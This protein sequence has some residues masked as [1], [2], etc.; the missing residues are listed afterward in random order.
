MSDTGENLLRWW[1]K[2]LRPE[3]GDTAAAR[4]LRAKLRRAD[5]A[6]EV[7]SEPAVYQ[8]AN[9]L[10]F[11]RNRPQDL[12]RLAQV[13]A[14]VKSHNKKR[15]AQVLGTGTPPPFSTQRFQRLIRTNEDGL[16]T[17]LR[18]A[19]PQAGETCDVAALGQDLLNWNEQTRIRWC[20]DYFGAAHPGA[21]GKDDAAGKDI[22]KDTTS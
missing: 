8:L 20:F 1:R 5:S 13:L 11:L 2:N 10:P 6:L 21:T 17:A 12:A 9:A 15:L 22:Q 16:A 4:A 19:L 3:E 14:S 18:R 7:L